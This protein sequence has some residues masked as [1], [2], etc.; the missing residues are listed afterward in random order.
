MPTATLMRLPTLSFYSLLHIPSYSIGITRGV[1]YL[2]HGDIYAAWEMNKISFL[3]FI[4]MI[5]IMINDLRF[6]A[7]DR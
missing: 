1:S 4:V 2:L 7:K 3:V 5:A 6:L